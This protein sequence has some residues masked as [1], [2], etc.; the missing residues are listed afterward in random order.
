MSDLTGKAII[1]TGA[2]GAIGFAAAEVLAGKG[3]KL[4]LVD[5]VADRLDAR[6]AELKAKGVEVVSQQADCSNETAVEN[7]G[8]P[9]NSY[10]YIVSS[11]LSRRTAGM[12]GTAIAA[13]TGR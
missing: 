2:A 5:I 3:A 13:G 8:L 7:V 11:K 10:S 4:F 6:A 1:V 9:T 12:L